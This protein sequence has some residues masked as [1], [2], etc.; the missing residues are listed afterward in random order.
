V[1]DC[2]L[3][4]DVILLQLLFSACTLFVAP[5]E[6]EN[7]NERAATTITMERENSGFLDFM[8]VKFKVQSQ[9]Q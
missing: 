5:A 9:L 8:G 6:T 3:Q 7:E 1:V 2:F 4:Y